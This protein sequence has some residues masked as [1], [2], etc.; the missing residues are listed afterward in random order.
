MVD[1]IH[2]AFEKL[3]AHPTAFWAIINFELNQRNGLLNI[4]GKLLPPVVQDIDNEITGFI[5]TAE[6]DVE[7][8]AIL[9][10]NPAG[11]ILLLNSHIMVTG[12]SVASRFSTPRIGA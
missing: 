6:L 1:P 8:A 10:D 11:N 9:I 2:H 4:G 7:G 3:S 5:R 12:L